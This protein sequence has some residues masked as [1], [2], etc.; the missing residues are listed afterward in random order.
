[1]IFNR[2]LLRVLVVFSMGCLVAL[3]Q[4]PPVSRGAEPKGVLVNEFLYDSASFPSCH[5]STI[6]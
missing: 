4:E 5:A 2:R 6:E 3:A 1:M